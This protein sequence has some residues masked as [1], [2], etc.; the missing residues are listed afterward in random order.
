MSAQT[1]LIAPVTPISDSRHLGLG[2]VRLLNKALATEIVCVLRYRRHHFMARRLGSNRIAE[3][4]LLHADEELSQA[5]LLAERIVQ[6]GGEPDFAPQTL[7]E[8]THVEYSAVPAAADMHQEILVAKIGA[9]NSYRGLIDCI[10]ES[11]PITRR[12]LEGILGVEQA[13]HEELLELLPD[14]K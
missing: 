12:L 11:D 7:Q 2:L 13:H 10:G 6:L 9:I 5:D 3:E 14:D 4:F 1:K 8:R